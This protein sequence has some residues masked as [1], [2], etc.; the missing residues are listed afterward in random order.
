MGKFLNCGQ[1]CIAPDYILIKSETK[2]S[3][4]KSIIIEIENAFGSNVK[5]SKDYGRIIH[6]NISKNWKM[7]L[8]GQ[9]ILYGGIRNINELFWTYQYR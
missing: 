3:L 1:T 6:K 4:V 9:S 8:K 5:N 2:E 7:I